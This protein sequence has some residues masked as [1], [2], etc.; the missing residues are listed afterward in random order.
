MKAARIVVLGIALGAGGI[1][2]FLAG[3]RKPVPTVQP[4]VVQI[5]T[6]DVLTARID[7]PIGKAL[8]PQ[9]VEWQTWPTKYAI[10]QFVRKTEN[11]DIAGLIT[12][13]VARAAFVAGEPIREAKLFKGNPASYMAAQLPVGMRAVSTEI[14]PESSAGGFIL[15][16]DRVDVILTSAEKTSGAET[17]KSRTILTDIRVLAIDQNVEEKSGQKTVMG[18]IATLEMVP[19]DAEKLSLARRLGNI[20]LILRGMAETAADSGAAS[21]LER[22][23]TISI[24]RFGKSTA[25]VPPN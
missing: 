25:E 15:P 24:V 14:S 9:D 20:S 8:R 10:S 4:P 23:N 19:A 2:A 18:K 16:N 6:T 1:A 11:P 17:Y 21:S 7:I 12:G 3:D 13:S 22:Q 5:E